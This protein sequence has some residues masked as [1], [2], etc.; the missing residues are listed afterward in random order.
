MF[1]TLQF[2]FPATTAMLQDPSFLNQTPAFYGGQQVN[3]V[4]AQT[5]RT[6]DTKFEWPPF[7]DQSVND[8]TATVGKG[9]A[10]KGD[11]GA[12]SNDWQNQLVSYAKDQ[13][14]TVAGK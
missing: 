2:F 9:L 7:L 5:S 8:W 13:G 12:G 11:L 10:N 3:K 1:T 4:F 14:F 6:V